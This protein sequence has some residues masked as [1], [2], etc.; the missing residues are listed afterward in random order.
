[1]LNYA[2]YLQK[3]TKEIAS[4]L[5]E[6]AIYSTQEEF[7]DATDVYINEN[8]GEFMK[9]FKRLDKWIIYYEKYI[10]SAVSFKQ[11]YYILLKFKV[12]LFSFSCQPSIE[13]PGVH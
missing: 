13:V 7:R 5:L 1:M 12:D 3:L 9:R 4:K 8:H 6:T 10:A 11:I 2:F